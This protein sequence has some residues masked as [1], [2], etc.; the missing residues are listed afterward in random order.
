MARIIF[1]NA[2][3]VDGD[4]PPRDGATIV[5]VGERIESIEF[6]R[7]VESRPGDEVHDL[8][9]RSVMPGLI[10]GHYHA[11]YT[12]LGEGGHVTAPGMEAPPALQALRASRHLKMAL[13]AGFTGVVSGGAPYAIDASCKQAIADGV[14]EGPRIIAG[15][16]DVSTTGHAQDWWQW[17][18]G[19]GMTAQTNIVDG[20]DAFR[21]AIREEV[22]RGSEIIKIFAT[23][24]HAIKGTPGLEVTEDEL[25]AAADAATQRNARIRA[26]IVG[27]EP[28]LAALRAG[29]HVIDHGDGID[30]ECID[31]LCE[32]QAPFIPSML[33]PHRV[34]QVISGPRRDEMKADIDQ[35][36]EV[37]PAANKAGVVLTLGDD[38]GAVPLDHGAYAD[39][40]EY[41]VHEAGI[42]P[43][44]VIRWGTKNGAKLMRMEHDLGT[45][46][47]GKLA[48]LIVVDGCPVADVRLLKA[49]RG[50]ILAV[51]K[52]GVFATSRLDELKRT[53]AKAGKANINA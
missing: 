25:K 32:T 22:K 3:L 39:E 40:L 36:L 16:R 42:P 6:S 33:Y 51:M 8:G 12:R 26:H 4:N 13:H 30:S 52:G 24:G 19:P 18:W 47:V 14:I 31:R 49:D 44:D 37:L 29:V 15:S 53:G 5:I 17:H 7:P 27:K 23:A 46:E 10:N 50:G 9:G 28:I 20:P 48:D 2:R 43:L 45:L 1:T 41:Y 35:M 38:F 21:K 11:T 34:V